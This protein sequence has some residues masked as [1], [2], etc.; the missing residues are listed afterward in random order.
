MASVQQSTPEIRSYEYVKTLLVDHCQ[1]TTRKWATLQRI[2]ERDSE[3]I[4]KVWQQTLKNSPG[5]RGKVVDRAQ[6]GWFITERR[7]D[8][9][10]VWKEDKREEAYR[11]GD[12]MFPHMSREDL[13]YEDM[14]PTFLYNR[15]KRH[16]TEYCHADLYSTRGGQDKP[17]FHAFYAGDKPFEPPSDIEGYLYS[18]KGRRWH[19]I[20]QGP[21]SMD[22]YVQEHEVIQEI[23]QNTSGAPD[24]RKLVSKG[25]NVLDKFSF[26]QALMIA[27]IQRRVYTFLVNVCLDLMMIHRNT[28]PPSEDWD[29]YILVRDALEKEYEQH[30]SNGKAIDAP[31]GPSAEEEKRRKL[32][33]DEDAV[34]L[35]VLTEVRL[36]ATYGAP[37]TL[38]WDALG[39]LLESRTSSRHPSGREHWSRLKSTDS[40]SHE[41]PQLKSVPKEF[42]DLDPWQD[43]I[44][45]CIGNA[46]KDYDRWSSINDA[47][48]HLQKVYE[49]NETILRTKNKTD[50]FWAAAK[51]LDAA[52]YGLHSRALDFSETL[53]GE[54][55]EKV[56]KSPFY[57]QILK[58]NKR[59]RGYE[60]S[61]K[62]LKDRKFYLKLA[63]LLVVENRTRFGLSALLDNFERHIATI[64][65]P[66]T[67]DNPP[68]GSE[69]TTQEKAQEK[70]QEEEDDEQPAEQEEPAAEQEEPAA[71]QEGTT[72]EQGGTSGKNKKKRKKKKKKKKVYLTKDVLKVL[73]DLAIFAECLSQVEQFQPWATLYFAE[74]NECPE[75]A[76]IRRSKEELKQH[77]KELA[78]KRGWKRTFRLGLPRV[79]TFDYPVDEERTE[80][81]VQRLNTSDDNLDH[82]WNEF[83]REM[84]PHRQD[85]LSER[86]RNLFESVKDRTKWK[87]PRPEGEGDDE[88]EEE[89]EEEEDTQM[90]D[91]PGDTAGPSGSVAKTPSPPKRPRGDDDDDDGEPSSESPPKKRKVAKARKTKDKG[92]QR[93]DRDPTK[94]WLP[95]KSYSDIFFLFCKPGE[96]RGRS[97]LQWKDF[98]KLMRAIGFG[99]QPSGGSIWKFEP[100]KQELLAV[101]PKDNRSQFRADSPHPETALRFDQTRRIGD[102][103]N[104]IYTWTHDTFAE[105]V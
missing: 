59:L 39:K 57:Q 12:Y 85:A 87:T 25:R 93:A 18:F 28:M 42:D 10:G 51:E 66:K 62:D 78:S 102:K 47:F 105:E 65:Q 7:T 97:V 92:K 81:N 91:V 30:E 44:E 50:K 3:N 68:Q 101:V 41:P 88:E 83:I 104:R 15:G 56:D 48:K 14:I 54:L 79:G 34:A 8:I 96:T 22:H 77:F 9:N 20:P 5:K 23:P 19:E 76:E 75:K 24:R 49:N 71:E 29:P 64:A 4:Y 27:G 38:D 103:L 84:G 35:P 36:R 45:F 26:G 17:A 32:E 82:F 100:V 89:E 31:K 2:L 43:A 63:Y 90:P 13:V 69:E 73:G 46:I 95:T 72:A 21:A 33:P 99:A 37:D 80:W 86:V 55:A 1:Q 94:I 98:L 40:S 74:W 53:V 11:L 6:E 61:V 58:Y 16:W 60:L 52:L 70:P 67:A